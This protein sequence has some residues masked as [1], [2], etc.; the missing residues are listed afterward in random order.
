VDRRGL[1]PDRLLLR[2]AQLLR[3]AHPDRREVIAPEQPA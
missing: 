2:V 1:Q 3:H